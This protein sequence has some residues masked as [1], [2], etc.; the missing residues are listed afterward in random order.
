M[1]GFA[2]H[3]CGD[4]SDDRGAP[5]ICAIAR[6]LGF[7]KAVDLTIPSSVLVRADEVIE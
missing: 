7:A 5:S 6:S 1:P 3:C 2:L 4:S